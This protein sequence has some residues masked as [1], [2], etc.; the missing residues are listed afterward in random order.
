MN[1]TKQKKPRD[2]LVTCQELLFS[3]QNFIRWVY[4]IKLYFY[5]IKSNSVPPNASYCIAVHKWGFQNMSRKRQWY[6]FERE[7]IS[8]FF[9]LLPTSQGILVCWF[10]FSL[11]HY[12]LSLASF[13]FSA[14]C[15]TIPGSQFFSSSPSLQSSWPSHFHFADMHWPL[16]H[17]NWSLEQP[18]S[19]YLWYNKNKH[20]GDQE[21]NINSSKYTADHRN[22]SLYSSELLNTVM[23]SEIKYFLSIRFMKGGLHPL[24][25][26]EA[27]EVQHGQ[28][29]R[30]DKRD[31]KEQKTSKALSSELLLHNSL[32]CFLKNHPQTKPNHTPAVCRNSGSPTRTQNISGRR[33]GPDHCW[34]KKMQTIVKHN[35]IL[36]ACSLFRITISIGLVLI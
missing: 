35:L 30:R 16:E 21:F 17:W 9:A 34:D 6:T 27:S 20:I 32:H 29:R 7:S 5:I 10:I 24:R 23:P 1:T 3:E 18:V 36:F 14:L 11:F 15:K 26:L 25:R 28:E 19:Q 31:R 12:D 2:A 4:I 22:D 33:R 8:D 13:Y